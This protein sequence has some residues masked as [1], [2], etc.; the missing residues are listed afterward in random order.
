MCRHCPLIR[1]TSP[2]SL[3][4]VKCV[5]LAAIDT[6]SSDAASNFVAINSSSS[7]ILF[8][9]HLQYLSRAVTASAII[10]G[11]LSMDMTLQLDKYL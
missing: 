9:S 3:G 5:S 8:W 6:N 11:N 7:I 2:T 1:P 4:L 10:C